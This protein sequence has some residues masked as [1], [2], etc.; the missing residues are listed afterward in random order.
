LLIANGEVDD[1]GRAAGYWIPKS[2]IDITSDV[3]AMG[4]QGDLVVSEW[5][6][7]QSGFE[8]ESTEG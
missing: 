2:Q 8:I 1:Q 7:M 4:D 6:A 5:I 3:Q